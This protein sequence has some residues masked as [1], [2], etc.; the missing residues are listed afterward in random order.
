VRISCDGG[1]NIHALWWDEPKGAPVVLFLHGNAQEAYS[2]SLVRGELQP[3]GCRMLLPDYRGY[4][5]S[6]GEPSE[7]ALYADGRAC[8]RWL[9]ERGV[10]GSDTVVF[11]KSLGGAVACEIARG[12][13]LRALI[14]E[15]TFSSLASVAHHLFPGLPA[16]TELPESYASIDKVAEL[17]CPVLVIHGDRDELIPLEDGLA[18]YEAAPQPKRLWV[19]E[20]AGHND[21]SLVAG[22]AYAERIAAFLREHAPG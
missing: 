8:L 1:V 10:G 4:G 3:L 2:W 16:G 9:Q 20:G 7:E 22:E 17:R 13:D 15:S 5:K 19:V 11:G 14:L 6:G 18:L 21:V 12:R